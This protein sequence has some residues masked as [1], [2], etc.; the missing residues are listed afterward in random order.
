MRSFAL[1]LLLFLAGGAAFAQ[2]KAVE[3]FY[4]GAPDCPY[5]RQ[6][7]SRTRPAF[8][9]SPEGKA[10][11]YVEIRGETL[12]QPIEARHYPAKYQWV[13]EQVGDSRGVPQFLLAEDGRVMHRAFGT[14]GFEKVFL[15]ALRKVLARR[16]M[17][18]KS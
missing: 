14:D 16:L 5:C 15:P 8:L 6:W 1:S 3:V 17:E 10:V 13:Y 18:K 2:A 4:L 7:E 11:T 12:R 9:A